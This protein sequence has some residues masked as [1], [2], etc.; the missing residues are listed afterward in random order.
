MLGGDVAG[1]ARRAGHEVVALARTEL[2]VTDPERGAE[3]LAEHRPDA[4]VNCAAWTD[5]D[6]AEAKED[7][8]LAANA[9]AGFFARVAEAGAVLLHVSTDYVFDGT[10][11]TP[12]VEG[13]LPAPQGAY[14]RTKLAGE[15]A[16]RAA[17]GPY[18][19]V[20]SGWLYGAGGRNFVETML[21][22]GRERGHVRVVDDQ[23]GC[24][25]STR[26]LAEGLVDLLETDARGLWHLAAEGECT[27]F[28]L[29][30]EALDRA[31]IPCTV[32]PT[33]TAELGRPAP[34][35]AYSVLR[36]E[37]GAPPL[38]HW[39]KG[40]ARYLAERPSAVTA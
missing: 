33:T 13:D 17:G 1:A 3:R 20:R 8:A 9:P 30:R 25:T 10:K 39:R 22:L 15:E 40:L 34:R 6:G 36:S 24:P 27:W 19:V 7:R 18:L 35:P 26:D 21:R 12:Y 2:D 23:L 11:R 5:V 38:P 16:A 29:A 32:E 28:A 31:G 4:V 37:R 14:G